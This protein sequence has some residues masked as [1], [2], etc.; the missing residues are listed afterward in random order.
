MFKTSNS[1]QSWQ[2]ISNNLPD[3]PALT[4]VLDP[5]NPGMIYLGTDIGV[6]RST[7]DGNSWTHYNAGLANVPVYDLE[8]NQT[9]RH[10]WAGTH[11]RG[12]FRLNLG[13]GQVPTPTPTRPTQMALSLI[14]I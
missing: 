6:F 13:G 9:T 3:I 12:V 1:G 14:H 11:G 8:L 2:N 10:L 7:N 5:D 4:I